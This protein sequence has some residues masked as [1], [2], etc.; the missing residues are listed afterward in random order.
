M[1]HSLSLVFINFQFLS[2]SD[3]IEFDLLID[4]KK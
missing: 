4:E 2:L 3:F 1:V